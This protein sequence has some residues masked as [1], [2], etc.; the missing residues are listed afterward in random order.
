MIQHGAVHLIRSAF[1]EGICDLTDAFLRDDDGNPW[2]ISFRDSSI[3]PDHAPEKSAACGASPRKRNSYRPAV[4][5]GLRCGIHKPSFC[6]ISLINSI[7]GFLS[8][9]A[10][11]LV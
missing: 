3:R 8:V 10:P 4:I 6:V 5:I 11:L 7:N 2:L 9:D 1:S